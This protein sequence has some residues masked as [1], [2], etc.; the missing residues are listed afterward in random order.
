MATL[1]DTGAWV[2]HQPR[3]NMNNAVG[4]ADA[5]AMLRGGVKLALGNDG[6]SNDMFVEMKTAYLLHKSARQDPLVL[7]ADNLLRVAVDHNAALARQFFPRPLGRLE[8]GAFA[9][10]ILVDYDPPTPLTLANLPWHLVFGC[11]GRNVDTTI[12]GGRV[13]MRHG[14][15]PHL[16]AERIYAR[17]REAAQATWLRF[18]DHS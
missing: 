11:D 14:I 8:P 3:S 7:P 1:R 15:I 12:V 13:L 5:P 10:L 16:D 18:W 9:D 4:V 6:F 2:S 17:S